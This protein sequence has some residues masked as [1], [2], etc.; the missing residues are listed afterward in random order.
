VPHGNPLPLEWVA[1]HPHHVTIPGVF[2]PHPP[3]EADMAL[4]P[5]PGAE[6]Q[7]EPPPAEPT[8]L[9][10]IDY[11]GNFIARPVALLTPRPPPRTEPPSARPQEPKPEV[12]QES[13]PAVRERPPWQRGAPPPGTLLYP[14]SKEKGPRSDYLHHLPPPE[15][16]YAEGPPPL[17]P[18]NQGKIGFD[19]CMPEGTHNLMRKTARIMAGINRSIR[20]GGIATDEGL[21]AAVG[22]GTQH[23]AAHKGD[24][25]AA[26]AAAK[27]AGEAGHA[28]EPTPHGE[29]SNPGLMDEPVAE[30]MRPHVRPTRAANAVFLAPAATDPR[31]LLE[32]IASGN[33]KCQGF[34][35]R[36]Q[37]GGSFGTT[38]A[39]KVS[40]RI[41][42]ASCAE[43]AF[44]FTDLPGPERA[45]ALSPFSLSPD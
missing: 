6:E 40:G 3:A 18:I 17:G 26:L 41:L 11:A 33:L 2:I 34:G 27:A 23:L 1:A 36:C 15:P 42:C 24:V 13:A 7:A 44:G 4:E 25:R 37:N 21:S 12:E 20:P 30:F 19:L 5:Q 8:Y 39:Y 28:V 38:G 10:E 22:A 31:S 43:K 32:L 35:G 9:V 16:R 45:E 29:T 14:C